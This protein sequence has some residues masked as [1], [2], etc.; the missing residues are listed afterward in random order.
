M[1][2]Y[3]VGR[4]GQRSKTFRTLTEAKSFQATARDPV[5]ARELRLLERGSVTL[6]EYFDSWLPRK[7]NLSASTRA[8]YEGVG[9]KYIVPGWLGAMRLS[10]IGRQDVERWVTD[11]ASHC[12]PPTMDK[13]YR[14]L[15]A[16]LSMAVLDG[17]IPSN[18]ATRVA[19]PDIPERRPFFLTAD[20]VAAIAEQ[21]AER[22][23]ALLCFLSYTGARMG[24][25]TALRVQN[26]DLIRRRAMIVENSPEVSGRKLTTKTKS[27]TA[28]I[29]DMSD[30]LAL[31]L[32]QHL[33]KFGQ[34]VR[35]GEID[36]GGYVFTAAHG[37]QVRQ[38][39]WRERVFQPA[40]ARAGVTRRASNGNIEVPCVHD[41]RHTA[42]SLAA[43]EGGTAFMKSRRCSDSPQSKSRA[44]ATFICSTM[45]RRRRRSALGG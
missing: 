24:E 14:T 9:A 20:Q 34:R 12:E 19:M 21:L 40:C 29:V 41:L 1:V 45:T 13:T 22:D 16:C 32:S 17:L 5:K 26:L 28:R 33:E 8:R 42:A 30:E 25:A 2:S 4:V 6:A 23:R 39:N 36:Q 18:P 15:R 11:L 44:T 37:G 3:R 7:R 35:L 10:D 27:K 38:S 31:E 43:A